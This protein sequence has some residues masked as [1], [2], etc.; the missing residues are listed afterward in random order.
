M[1]NTSPIESPDELE[2]KGKPKGVKKLS[3]KAKAIGFI[4]VAFLFGLL[5]IGMANSDKK[6]TQKKQDTT[7]SADDL[8][9]SDAAAKEVYKGKPDGIAAA[10]NGSIPLSGAAAGQS[11]VLPPG[12]L[13]VGQVPP[14]Q[15]PGQ[16]PAN[17]GTIPLTRTPA[18]G[19]STSLAQ[20]GTVPNL[21]SVGAIKPAG[22][23]VTKNPNG[24][25]ALQ[26]A[27]QQKADAANKAQTASSSYGGFGDAGN[28]A[29]RLAAAAGTAP[30]PMLTAA[31]A[32]A[33]LPL[34]GQPQ[35]DDPNKQARKEAFI[36]EAASQKDDSYLLQLRKAPISP[37]EVKAGT[38]IPATMI[39]GANSDLP[40]QMIAQVR[41]NV[42]DTATGRYLLIPQGT[43]L[44]GIYDS[45]VAYG[46]GRLLTVWQRM[47]FPDA[48]SIT[49]QGM[50]GADQGGYGGFHDQVDNHYFRIFGSAMLM[51]AISAGTQLSQPN[52]AN[53]N[54]ANTAPT[55]SQVLAGALGQQLGQAG[56]TLLQ[57]NLNI[58]PTIT[59]RNGYRFNVMVTKDMLFAGAYR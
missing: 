11:G 10:D 13:A 4:I 45:Q 35:Q 53:S 8:E 16:P 27:R 19:Q 29:S 50:P 51:S 25:Y 40:G 57:K 3:K 22:Y 24:T 37:F 59:I 12:Q 23:T 20:N 49:L 9:P 31:A 33:A 46:Q 48:S 28:A 32:P 36:K 41:E 42:Y 5:L 34:S 17:N 6:N 44:I 2:L 54:G 52:T 21:G 38:V 47:I 55:A 39:S 30:A 14:G 1:A 7:A 56:T 43:R 26:Q 15:Q 18:A 58:Q